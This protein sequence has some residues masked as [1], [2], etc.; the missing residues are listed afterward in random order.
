[1]S[2]SARSM[3]CCGV[4]V[5]WLITMSCIFG[6]LWPRHAGPLQDGPRGLRTHASSA[7]WLLA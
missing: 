4:R 5:Q 1:M 7:T 3:P 6:R 2:P